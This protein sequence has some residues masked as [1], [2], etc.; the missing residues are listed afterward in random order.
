MTAPATFYETIN[1][2]RFN[3]VLLELIENQSGAFSGISWRVYTGAFNQSLCELYNFFFANRQTHCLSPHEIAY[4]AALA[5]L[6]FTL[7]Q[8][9]T[10]IPF[11]SFPCGT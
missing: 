7:D 4:F 10:Q 3:I 5:I 8:V 2:L 11:F 6:L 9:G 1:N